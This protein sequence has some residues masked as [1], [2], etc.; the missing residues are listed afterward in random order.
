MTIINLS[1]A[2]FL[3]SILRRTTIRPGQVV[4]SPRGLKERRD[5]RATEIP[6]GDTSMIN[7]E[8][9]VVYT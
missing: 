5:S 2:I 8:I 6:V 3:A 4:I 1:P 9:R 7:F